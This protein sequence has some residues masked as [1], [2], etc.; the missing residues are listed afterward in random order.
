MIY[1]HVPRPTP[2]TN[3]DRVRAMSDEE[4]AR[5]LMKSNDCDVHIPFCQCKEECWDNIP[6]IP[7]EN[8][9]ACMVAWLQE[10]AE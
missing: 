10:E 9:L 6:D 1:A 8:C 2:K 7:A 5:W 3:A 4:L